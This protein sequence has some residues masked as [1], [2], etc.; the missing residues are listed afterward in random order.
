MAEAKGVELHCLSPAGCG[1]QEA[2]DD[3]LHAISPDGYADVCV[4]VPVP[5]LVAYGM[6]FAADNALVNVFAGI[7]IGN[8]A[9][10]SLGDLC[11]GVKLIGSSGSRIRDLRKILDMVEGNVLNT[12][13]SVAA[14]GGLNVG[15]EGLEA[16][17]SG[18]FPGKTVV[19]PQIADLPL[20]SLEE[21][22]DLIPGLRD[23][24]GPNC[25][26]TKQAERA[27]MEEYV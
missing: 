16:V 27:L 22:P 15:R 9:D 12:D 21:I 13:L 6:T 14:I 18:R 5:A 25:T 8:A 10:V 23:R 3:R 7:P 17:K 1:S 24:L 20:M 4:L 11:R 2:M 26:W 19:Y